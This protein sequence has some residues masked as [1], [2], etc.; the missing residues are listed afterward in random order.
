MQIAILALGSRGDVQ[1]FIA[2]GLALRRAG[3]AVR[4]VGLA[5][6]AELAAAYDRYVRN[7]GG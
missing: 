3:H 1:P 6:Y 5:D 2:L 7:A 4:L